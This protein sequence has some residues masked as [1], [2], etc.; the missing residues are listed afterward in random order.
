MSITLGEYFVET[1]KTVGALPV[2]SDDILGSP[3]C[4]D[5]INLANVQPKY[6]KIHE[7][8]GSEL[9]I[10]T[11]PGTWTINNVDLLLDDDKFADGYDYEI[12]ITYVW[13]G[14]TPPY[15]DDVK[16]SYNLGGLNYFYAIPTLVGT[17]YANENNCGGSYANTTRVLRVNAAA[18]AAFQFDYTIEI[19]Q[20]IPATIDIELCGGAKLINLTELKVLSRVD[21]VFVDDAAEPENVNVDYRDADYDPADLGFEE[22]AK[23][24]QTCLGYSVYY[25]SQILSSSFIVVP[26]TYYLDQGIYQIKINIP[27]VPPK[28]LEFRL[29]DGLVNQYLGF[30]DV[31]GLI[32]WAGWTPPYAPPLTELNT[33]LELWDGLTQETSS[34]EQN[35]YF[36]YDLDAYDCPCEDCGGGCGEINVNFYQSCGTVLPLKFNLS[37][38]EGKYSIDGETFTQANE[39]IR[40]V[41]KIKA[42][43]DFVISNYSDET[44]LLLMDL[45][46]D[47]IKIGVIDNIDAGSPETFYYIDT[48][49]LTPAWNFNSKLGDLVIPV[50]K[51][52]SIKTKRRNCCN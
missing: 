19:R 17:V 39:I 26:K 30:S 2:G 23:M 38:Q 46:S 31:N 42:T 13:V 35:V 18:L 49:V 28:I 14:L 33:T 7:Y 36:R 41:T 11:I 45:I 12:I 6:K 21:S 5:S 32:D 51:E 22:L 44:F 50:I 52:N 3:P 1:K 10:Q 9:G 8:T 37:V 24:P 25:E 16:F 48:E 40:P 47:N 4:N 43:Y 34:G 15:I 20:L 27:I 29:F